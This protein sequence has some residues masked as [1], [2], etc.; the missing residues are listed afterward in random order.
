MVNKLTKYTILSL[1]FNN[2]N[3]SQCNQMELETRYIPLESEVYFLLRLLLL[4]E[5]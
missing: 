4:V 5:K 1:K 3:Y 2:Y